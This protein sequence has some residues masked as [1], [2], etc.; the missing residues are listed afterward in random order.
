MA[1]T[2]TETK[3]VIHSRREGD[4]LVKLHAETSGEQVKLTTQNGVTNEDVQAELEAVHTKINGLLTS[5]D[6]MQFKGVVNAEDDLPTTYEPGWT[7]KVGTAG[8]Y[9]GNVC[10]VGDM[11][12]ATVSRAGTDNDNADFAAVQVNIDGAVT[13]PVSAV[14][15][16]LAAFDQATGKVVKDSGLSAAELGK[17]WVK[18]VTALPEDMPADLKDGGL[19]IV[20]A[21]A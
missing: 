11:L 16:N 20:D 6:A 21:G 15:G 12:I 14:D 7:W 1:I 5:A 2:F 9:K 13:G 18:T 17:V 3:N 19:L 10:E 8:T 4:N